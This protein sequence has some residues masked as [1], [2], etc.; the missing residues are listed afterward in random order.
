MSSH[1]SH[2]AEAAVA[3]AVLAA[4]LMVVA[5]AGGGL[6]GMGMGMAL[7]GFVLAG[8][9]KVRHE[10]WLPQWLPLLLFPVLLVTSP[11]WV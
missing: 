2:L 4:M 7:V 3:V 6:G 1:R 9:A 5:L 11:F 10:H 8:A